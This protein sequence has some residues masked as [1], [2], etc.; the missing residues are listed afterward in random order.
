MAAAWKEVGRPAGRHGHCGGEYGVMGG[1]WCCCCCC[2][3]PCA[4]VSLAPLRMKPT[5]A[6][7]MHECMTMMMAQG[8]GTC[9]SNRMPAGAATLTARDPTASLAHAMPSIG[10]E[11]IIHGLIALVG[12]IMPICHAFFIWPVQ[13]PGSDHHLCSSFV[14]LPSP[15]PR[16]HDCMKHDPSASSPLPVGC[17]AM[18][19]AC[20]LASLISRPARPCP[21]ITLQFG[22]QSRSKICPAAPLQGISIAI[23][24]ASLIGTIIKG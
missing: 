1:G 3:M 11:P 7:C 17:P 15:R 21:I 5:R 2:C 18:R 6:L 24:C 10:S 13:W 19:H 8:A 14:P 4:C 22:T 23:W 16:A 12:F 20:T 9:S